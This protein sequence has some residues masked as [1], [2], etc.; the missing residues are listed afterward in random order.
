[1]PRGVK[2]L[3]PATKGEHEALL[4]TSHTLA[5]IFGICERSVR[6]LVPKGLPKRKD[7]RF[8]L[9]EVVPL[10]YREMCPPPGWHQSVNR[11]FLDGMDAATRNDTIDDAEEWLE[12]S[13]QGVEDDDLFDEDFG[14]GDELEDI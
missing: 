5:K 8:N 4:V 12:E 3:I 13:L 11:A 6:R 1:M 7:G 14:E 10:Y 9:V 2:T